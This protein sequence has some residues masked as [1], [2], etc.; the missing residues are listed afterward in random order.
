MALLCSQVYGYSALKLLL[1]SLAGP[2]VT[3][4]YGFA[5]SLVDMVRRYLPV[6]LLLGM[7]R[8]LIIASYAKEMNVERPLFLTNLVFK[9]NVF[10]IAPMFAVSIAFGG[11]LMELIHR[12]KYPDAYA[13]LIPFLVILV[14]QTLHMVLSMLAM[15]LEH[16][17]LILRGTV[18]AISGIV[19]AAVLIPSMGAWGAVIGAAVSEVTFCAMVAGAI[20]MTY[21]RAAVSWRGHLR[22]WL[23]AACT[24]AFAWG[25]TAG[26]PM[27]GYLRA[28]IGSAMAAIAYFSLALWW[29]PFSREQRDTLNRVLPRPVFVW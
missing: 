13:I 3:A 7:V 9:L 5:H 14:L 12:G 29:R 22:I 27:E 20:T 25:A 8:P 11:P 23:L 24:A 28:I 2:V 15:S 21:R 19:I 6:Q 1:S 18:I 17:G 10:L 26:L 16:G 4:A